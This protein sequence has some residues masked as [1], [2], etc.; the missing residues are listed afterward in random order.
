MRA[1][2]F[3]RPHAA[4]AIED[5]T[6]LDPGPHDVVVRITASGVCHSDVSAANGALSLPPPIVLGHEG[7]GIV[8]AVG[9]DVTRVASGDRVIGSFIPV[10]GKCWY[11]RHGHTN[12]CEQTTPVLFVPRATRRNGTVASAFCGLGTFAEQMTCGE[13][14]VVPVESD[15]PDEQLALVG[16][17]LTTGVGAVLNT[18]RVE[19]GASV[20][21]V[22]CGG[23]GQAVVQGARIAGAEPI[24]AIDPVRLKRDT[25]L[26]LGAT[27]AIDPQA[28]SPSEQVR[29]LTEG[30]GVD[31]AFE[32][33]GT[34]STVL[35]AFDLTRRGGTCIAVGMHGLD[36]TIQIPSYPLVLQERRVLGCVYGSAQV[37]RDF[38][39]IIALIEDGALDVSHLVSRR[40]G[41][42]EVNAAFAAMNAGEVIR[43]VI[44]P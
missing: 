9:S 18:A 16:C 22:G 35:E 40:F 27:H 7:T 11:C 25:A 38:P 42:D 43:G 32:V 30:R 6:P 15:L 37:D 39:R 34:P 12:L 26:S 2:L 21:I 10:C 8:E 19:A 33:I 29:A 5:V 23:V 4:L 3:V 31:Y 14:S 1:A 13:I 41:L 24:I 20:A 28:A 17:A 36:E 44:N